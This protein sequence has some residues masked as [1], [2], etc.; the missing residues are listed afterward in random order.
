MEFE[1]IETIDQLRDLYQAPMDLALKKQ[2]SRLD[3]YSSQFLSLSAFCILSTSNAAGHMD[4]SP[5]GDYPGF[6]QALDETTVALPDRPGN[7]RL[8]SL[9]NIVENPEMGLLIII[10]GFSE[11]LRIN[12]AAKVVTNADV[13]KRFKYKGKLPKSVIIISIR[14]VYFHCAKAIVRAKLWQAE[15]QIA[16]STMPGLGAL[17]MAQ[18]DPSKTKEEVQEIENLIEESTKSTLY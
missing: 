15:S 11:C 9:S 12:G 3:K 4:C 6:I 2:Q 17:L 16:R 10:P 14:E 7:N 5:R 18:I 1:V 8:D 13:L